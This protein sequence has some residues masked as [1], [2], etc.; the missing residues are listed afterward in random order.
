[1]VSSIPAY[2]AADTSFLPTG[3]FPVTLAAGAAASL[4]V[5]GL[6]NNLDYFAVL[7]GAGA[8]KIFRAFLTV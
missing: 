5:F 1:M 8:V 6:R 4:A 3:N 7:A 2:N